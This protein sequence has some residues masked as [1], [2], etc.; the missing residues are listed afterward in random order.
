MRC[1]NC[2]EVTS[3]VDD[4]HCKKIFKEKMANLVNEGDKEKAYEMFKSFRFVKSFTECW[5]R[6]Q[7]SDLSKRYD[8][9]LLSCTDNQ[10]SLD[11]WEKK[12]LKELKQREHDR[13]E[14][15]KSEENIQIEEEN[16]EKWLLGIT[17]K[18]KE[19][20]LEKEEIEFLNGIRRYDVLADYY[21]T[22]YLK[23]KN[24]WDL[25]KASSYYRK[26]GDYEKV[27]LITNN[28]NYNSDKKALAAVLTSRGAAFKD[29][30]DLWEAE[31]C[32]NEALKLWT[33]FYPYLVLG[34][35][36]IK[37]GN[38]SLAENCF[39]EAIKLD[40]PDNNIKNEISIALN[41]LN[42]EEAERLAFLFKKYG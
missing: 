22:L 25:S 30:G 33:S 1:T 5:K 14:R 9:E 16:K 23:N 27:I 40:A 31:Q 2:G 35:I 6:E 11:E 24:F 8:Q 38:I 36:N 17:N 29:S 20:V 39:D 37:K 32:E 13:I 28:L 21:Y 19:E 7:F 42:E 10:D 41:G 34:S 26:N 12:R 4:L 18:I 3:L 15:K